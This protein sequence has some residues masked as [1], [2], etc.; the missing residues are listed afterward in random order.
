MSLKP[1][2]LIQAAETDLKRK[3]HNKNERGSGYY[4]Q[5]AFYRLH[6]RRGKSVADI[7]RLAAQGLPPSATVRKR[8][9]L[10][11]YAH[12]LLIWEALG[13]VVADEHC[14]TR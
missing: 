4:Q 11:I 14:W 10:I 6:V 2:N 1:Q 3:A 9:T 7:L 12:P 5:Y 13:M 8:E